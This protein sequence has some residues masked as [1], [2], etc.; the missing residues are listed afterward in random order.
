ME[1]K[2]YDRTLSI[3][4]LII[5]VDLIGFGILIP[6]IPLLLAD[7]NSLYYLLPK[8]AP[9]STG[10]FLLGLL[11]A[12]YPLM[13]FLA[14][15]ILGQLSDKYGRKKLLAVSVF[16]TF[17]SYII[18]A[19]GIITANLPVL[20][21][22]RAVDG[23]TGGN[24]S[25]AQA[26]V[27]DI[28]KP[29]NRAKNF[30][31]IGAAFGLGFILGPF[32][33]GKLSDPMVV[34]WFNA[35]TPFFFA[36]ILSFVEILLILYILPETLKERN[37]SKKLNLF[38]SVGNVIEAYKHKSVRMILAVA[39]M[40]N[41][42]FTFFTTFIAVLYIYRFNFTQGNIGD[43]FAYVGIC[44]AA[45]QLFI[46][47]R[48]PKNREYE[49]LGVGILGSAIMLFAY[50]FVGNPWELLIVIPIFAIFNGFVQAYLPAIVSR[51]AGKAIQGEILGINASVYSLGQLIP[52]ALAGYIAATFSV[53]IPILIAGII[54]LL[55]AGMVYIFKDEII[56][57]LKN[58]S[59]ELG[60][61]E[62]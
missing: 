28:T 53:D 10:Y 39:F 54:T 4:F 8:N 55:T 11:T 40:D 5:F 37:E 45:A 36:A 6:V 7:P 30:G 50:A 48:L 51:S 24:I 46:L 49:I 60:R 22:A 32:L 38:Q 27:A 29:E 61:K 35:S 9:V 23:I 18:F 44:F 59:N 15:P 47:P 1:K 26:A 2:L 31:L 57:P 34:S 58:S 13:Q 3:I 12:V 41:L 16:G 42:G 52:P 25:I 43:M 20:F 21:F 17:L 62:Q 19:F 56:A 14:A 33:G